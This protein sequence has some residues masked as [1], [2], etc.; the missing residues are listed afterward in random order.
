M[1]LC[2]GAGKSSLVAALLRL[3][4]IEG[5]DIVIDG[6]SVRS[7]PLRRLR[8]ALGVV[9]QAA[10]LFEVG[11]LPMLLSGCLT[12][13]WHMSTWNLP[14]R[15]QHS[16]MLQDALNIQ[17]ASCMGLGFLLL[18]CRCHYSPFISLQHAG[19]A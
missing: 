6:C 14:G 16:R 10:F 8:S 3:V 17:S 7:V 11:C 19:H 2:P 12:C 1:L 13:V 5:G 9:P 15:R 4:E 18:G